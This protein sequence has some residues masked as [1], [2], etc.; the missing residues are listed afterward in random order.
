M[1]ALYKNDYEKFID[2]NIVDVDLVIKLEEKMGFIA[3]VMT[4][5]Y[6]GKINYA[7]S[8]TTV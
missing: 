4:M 3:Q 7:D 1:Q 2:Y 5:S 8:L 6:E